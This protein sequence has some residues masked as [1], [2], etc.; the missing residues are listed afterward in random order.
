MAN[1]RV[2]ELPDEE[3]P[4]TTVEDA[5]ESSES[6]AEAAE[7][8]TIPGGAAIT[9]HS[10]NEK[11]ARKA[12]GKLGLKHVPGITRVTLRRPKNILFVIN[13]PDVYRSPSSNTWIIF[14]EAKIEDLNSQAQA[15]A[16]QQ[17]SAAEAAGNG[18]HAGHEHI[19]LGKG[20]A[21]ET[22]K[23][24]EEEEEEGEVDETGLEAKDIELVMAQANVSRSKAIKALKENDN[25]IVNSIMALSV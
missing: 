25:D 22:E 17:L 24:E 20:K 13:Q 10:R 3:V 6:E 18:E 14:G 15:S 19:D 4:K 21:P 1:P 11:K 16:A 23:K 12:I 7:E 8:P 9:V 2:E 5:G